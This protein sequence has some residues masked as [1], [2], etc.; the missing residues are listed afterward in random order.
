MSWCRVDCCPAGPNGCAYCPFVTPATDFC[1]S[2]TSRAKQRLDI[3][4]NQVARWCR[5]HN[6]RGKRRVAA[7]QPFFV[8]ALLRCKSES[9]RNDLNGSQDG[10]RF[11]HA[12]QGT[13][14]IKYRK[15]EWRK[16][17]LHHTAGL[18]WPQVKGKEV[19]GGPP[20]AGF[21][22]FV[23]S[24]RLALALLSSFEYMPVVDDSARTLQ[25]APVLVLVAMCLAFCIQMVLEASIA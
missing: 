6:E 18:P 17:I 7:P 20:D 2:K 1:S 5:I 3:R 24:G 25:L 12:E 4:S 8:H 19:K 9:L 22:M 10:P 21:A 14:Y 13:N 11:L 15:M 23:D 16:K